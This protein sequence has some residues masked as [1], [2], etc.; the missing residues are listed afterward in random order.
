MDISSILSGFRFAQS[1]LYFLG[2]TESLGIQLDK[3][4]QSKFNAAMRELKHAANSEMEGSEDEYKDAL[5]S[6]RRLFSE[7][8]SLESKERRAAAYVGL[9]FCHKNLGQ[10][11]NCKMTLIEFSEYKFKPLEFIPLQKKVLLFVPNFT[12]IAIM[13]TQ[14]EMK[15]YK[16]IKEMQAQ[17]KDYAQLL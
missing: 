17:A 13:M 2:L 11:Q 3:L 14:D 7:A 1:A 15:I 5:R 6:S 12:L 8:I 10:I 4:T 9:A 16:D